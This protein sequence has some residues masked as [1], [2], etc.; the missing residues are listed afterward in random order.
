MLILV[1]VWMELNTGSK[2]KDSEVRNESKRAKICG[3]MARWM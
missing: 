1:R 2:T 3:K